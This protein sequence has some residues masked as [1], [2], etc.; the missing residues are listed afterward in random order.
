MAR[1][2]PRRIVRARRTAPPGPFLSPVAAARPLQCDA[3]CTSPLQTAIASVL[4]LPRP[5]LERLVACLIERLDDYDGDPDCEP[6]S[7]N[8][9]PSQARWPRHR[10]LLQDTDAERDDEDVGVDDGQEQ[11]DERE[12]E[13]G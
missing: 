6:C 8:E 7:W 3:G 2:A 13:A 4:V 5:L 9:R 12:R 11:D 10:L 1:V